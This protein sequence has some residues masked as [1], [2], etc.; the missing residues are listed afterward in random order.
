MV[1]V[2]EFG[3]EDGMNHFCNPMNLLNDFDLHG[4]DIVTVFDPSDDTSS[5]RLHSSLS[6]ISL[7]FGLH[8]RFEFFCKRKSEDFGPSKDEQ[9]Q[10]KKAKKG[11]AKKNVK[12]TDL[13]HKH[14]DV[15]VDPEYTRKDGSD[16]ETDDTDRVERWKDEE[17]GEEEGG[18]EEDSDQ[19]SSV[20]ETSKMDSGNEKENREEDEGGSLLSPSSVTRV[21]PSLDAMEP[22]GGM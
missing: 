7:P 21:Y 8:F 16:M 1:A 2:A 11:S 22:A 20:K 15:E 4:N 13:S 5:L 17:V 6:A 10:S 9:K 19:K 3:D 18:E 12:D 14:K